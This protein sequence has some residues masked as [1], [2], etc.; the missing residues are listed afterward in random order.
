M[1][2]LVTGGRGFIGSHFV[3]KCLDEG[4]KVIDIDSM[5]Y[6]GNRHLPFDSDEKYEHIEKDIGSITHL[7]T[8]D[9][10]VNFA[11]ECHVDNSINEPDVFAQTNIIGTQNLLNVARDQNI[12]FI[13]VSTDE[14]YGDI[15]KASETGDGPVDA[16]LNTIKKITGKKERKAI[17]EVVSHNKFGT[18]IE[19]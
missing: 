7:P 18:P 3:E 19:I 11:A 9:I 12:P 16:A 14:V 2:F 6:A 8:C 5:T 13:H 15:K 10:L 1:K 4:H 17:D